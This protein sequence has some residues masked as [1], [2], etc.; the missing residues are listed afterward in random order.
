MIRGKV[1]RR[2]P[3]TGLIRC[4]A[5]VSGRRD[6]W[7]GRGRGRFGVLRWPIERF[8]DRAF[9]VLFDY[10]APCADFGLYPPP[11]RRPDASTVRGALKDSAAVQTADHRTYRRRVAMQQDRR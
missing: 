2:I 6:E 10:P 1:A 7:Q 5:L 8:Y 4:K 9:G 3:L 11:H